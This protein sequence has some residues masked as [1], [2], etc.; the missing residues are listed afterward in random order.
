MN[1]LLNRMNKC[2]NIDAIFHC[3]NYT[4]TNYETV[5]E[6][7]KSLFTTHQRITNMIDW[8]RLEWTKLYSTPLYSTMTILDQTRLDSAN[9]IIYNES[10][11]YYV[12]T[13]YSTNKLQTCKYARRSCVILAVQYSKADIAGALWRTE[14][15]VPGALCCTKAD[16]AGALPC[17]KA[18]IA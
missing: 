8:T 17:T 18:D 11:L 12:P 15:G 16:I 6:I 13:N 2:I 1:S 14:V 7:T 9:Y 5:P 10:T 3:K 4:P